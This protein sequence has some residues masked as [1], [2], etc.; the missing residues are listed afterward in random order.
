M[1]GVDPSPQQWQGIL[2]AVQEREILPFFDSAY[3]GFA[4]G[5]LERDAASI[6]L[7]ADTGMEL[8]LAQSFAKNMGLC[9]GVHEVPCFSERSMVA[10]AL[11]FLP[12]LPQVWRA[13]GCVECRRGRPC[14]SQTCVEPAAPDCTRD[15]FQPVSGVPVGC[16]S[17]LRHGG[18]KGDSR[19]MSFLGC[20][21]KHGAAVAATI[22]CDPELFAKWQV[23]LKGMADRIIAMRHRL[24]EELE[25]VGAPGNWDHITKAIGMFSFLGLTKEQVQRITAKW[26]VFMTFDGR[27]SMAGLS[28]EK[29]RYLAEAINDVVRTT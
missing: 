21:P 1:Q 17:A 23:E 8:L 12:I 22:L 10:A 13:C 7:F 26:H 6:R 15:V 18:L 2:E 3:Q 16:T 14:G 28:G 24:C 29:C 20:R 4:S 9:V 27:I 25:A 11:N 5:D 19:G